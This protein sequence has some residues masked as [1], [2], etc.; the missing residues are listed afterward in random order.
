[1][2][3]DQRLGP[4]GIRRSPAAI[5]QASGTGNGR[6]AFAAG[7]RF[8]GDRAQRAQALAFIDIDSMQKAV[9]GCG[10]R[11]RQDLWQDGAGVRA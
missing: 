4:G 7:P 3:A 10:I 5:H 1:M 11:A 2:G 9:S 6:H 8:I